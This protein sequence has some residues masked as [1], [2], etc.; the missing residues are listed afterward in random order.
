MKEGYKINVGEI[1]KI[2]R[3]KLKVREHYISEKISIK[4]K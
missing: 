2:G 1:I 4:E 3:F